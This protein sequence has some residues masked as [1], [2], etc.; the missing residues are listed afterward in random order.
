MDKEQKTKL[1]RIL[2]TI[3]LTAVVTWIDPAGW[4]RLAAFIIIYLIIGYDILAEAVEGIVHGEVFD[5]D[6]LM[7][8]ATIGAFA[9]AIYEGSGDYLEAIAVM[10]F[11][12]IGEFFEIYAVDKSRKDIGDLMDIRPDYANL[13]KDGGTVRVN[14]ADVAVG[15]T[16][17]V[18]PD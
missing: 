15:Q 1:I 14:P 7:A 8:V 12:Q 16:I 11:F 17:V 13:E 6:F 9:L 18:Q 4:P 5:E 2:I 3:L 10:L